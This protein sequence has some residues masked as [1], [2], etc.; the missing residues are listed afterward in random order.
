MIKAVSIKLHRAEGP[1]PLPDPV[2]VTGPDDVWAKAR[3]VLFLWSRTAPGCPGDRLA[4]GVDKTDFTV[5]WE[6]GETYDGTFGLTYT[7]QSL[8]GH[9]HRYLYYLMEDYPED[10]LATNHKITR[11][12]I[13]AFLD[14]HQIGA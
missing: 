14:T 7:D 3:E 8:P 11:A 13:R 9:I 1:T 4:L 12:D 10:M 2:T 5:T 6:D